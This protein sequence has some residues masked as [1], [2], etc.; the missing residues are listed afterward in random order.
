MHV[1]LND[2]FQNFTYTYLYF[3]NKILARHITLVITQMQMQLY[4]CEDNS[5]S[6]NAVKIYGGETTASPLIKSYCGKIIPPPL[7]SDG[8]A[9]TIELEDTMDFF[10]TYSVLDSRK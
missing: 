2:F 3:H 5:D 4:H 10:A 9:I 8:S 6:D 7:V 1:V